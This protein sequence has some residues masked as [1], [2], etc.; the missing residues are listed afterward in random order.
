MKKETL[1]TALALGLLANRKSKKVKNQT[2]ESD[3]ENSSL[4]LYLIVF[5]AFVIIMAF[6]WTALSKL[7]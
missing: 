4:L 2:V 3:N 7:L 5:I 1:Y 6:I